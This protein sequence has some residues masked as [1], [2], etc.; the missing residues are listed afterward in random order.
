MKPRPAGLPR[1]AS[2][3]FRVASTTFSPSS[4]SQMDPETARLALI[5]SLSE[6][7]L[8]PSENQLPIHELRIDLC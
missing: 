1:R 3:L 2:P 5:P 6:C 8:Q 4:L 7:I